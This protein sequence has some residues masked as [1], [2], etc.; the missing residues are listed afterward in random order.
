MQCGCIPALVRLAGCAAGELRLN[1]VWALQ[2]LA[3]QVRALFQAG[4][5]FVAGQDS[6]KATFADS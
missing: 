3:F 6:A 5:C 2:N 4:G 1:A